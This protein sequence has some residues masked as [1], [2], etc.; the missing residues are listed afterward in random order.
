MMGLI[1]GVWR[2]IKNTVLGTEI[3]QLRKAV[4][5]ARR[6]RDAAIRRADE[7]EKHLDFRNQ[8]RLK[9]GIAYIEGDDQPRCGTCVVKT[10]DPVP[11]VDAGTHDSQLRCKACNASYPKPAYTRPPRPT[12]VPRVRSSWMGDLR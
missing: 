3:H 2:W 9:N 4:D 5:D 12:P 6:E 11:L 7:A 8:V 1:K 10:G